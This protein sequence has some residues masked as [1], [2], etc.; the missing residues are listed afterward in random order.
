MAPKH[1]F[2]QMLLLI[3][4]Y[5]QLPPCS[6]QIPTI[7]NR[8]TTTPTPAM[9]TPQVPTTPNVPQM[10]TSPAT[11]PMPVTS[12]QSSPNPAT[13]PSATTLASPDPSTQARTEPP[14]Q[15]A[16]T[17]APTAQPPTTQTMP[18][19][20][21]PTI[22]PTEPPPPP[23]PS[24][25]TCSMAARTVTCEQKG[26]TGIPPDLPEYTQTLYLSKNTFNILPRGAFGHLP[27]LIN[28]HLV[29]CG[30]LSIAD[31]AFNGLHHLRVLNLRNNQLT[32]VDLVLGGMPELET[33]DLEHNRLSALSE[34]V[35][36]N[37]PNLR[38]L[39]IGS[40]MGL[41]DIS[42]GA[43]DSNPMLRSLSISY[44]A[45]SRLDPMMFRNLTLLETL[46][47]SGNPISQIPSGAFQHLSSLQELLLSNM[48]L[49]SLSDTAFQGLLQLRILNL[50]N[51]R[52]TNL[53]IPTL[54]PLTLL[55]TLVLAQNPWNCGCSM[56]NFINWLKNTSLHQ[57]D[58][59]TT[60]WKCYTPE[61]LQE[62]LAYTI[63]QEDF[64]CIPI[65]TLTP[66][67]RVISYHDFTVF[68]CTARGD[69]TPEIEWYQPD[70]SKVS[71]TSN[72]E[73]VYT[74]DDGTVL[75]IQ[76]PEAVN[77]GRYNCTARNSNGASS[78][79]FSLTV[80]GIPTT[81]G[82]TTTGEPTSVTTGLPPCTFASIQ[83]KVGEITDTT[84]KM[85]WTGYN[86]PYL[87][88]YIIQTTEFGSSQ[89]TIK[90][91]GEADMS[92]VV[93][94]LTAGT[95][96]VV[97][98]TV[99]LEMCPSYTTYDQCEQVTT[100]GKTDDGIAALVTKHRNEIIGT[101]LATFFG[102]LFIL[103]SIFVILWQYRKPKSFTG[104]DFK[105][106]QDTVQ[107]ADL[108][109][110]ESSTGQISNQHIRYTGSL[111][112]DNRGA[113]LPDEDEQLNRKQ[114]V[115]T[116]SHEAEVYS[117]PPDALYS[118]PETKGKS[119]GKGKG[120]GKRGS[121]APL[122][123][124]PLDQWDENKRSSDYMVPTTPTNDADAPV[125]E[126]KLVDQ[127]INDG[128]DVGEF[129]HLYE[130]L[131]SPKCDCDPVI[132][133]IIE[134]NGHMPNHDH[135]VTNGP[136]SGKVRF[137]LP[138]DEGKTPVANGSL[139]KQDILKV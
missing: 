60:Q 34:N 79:T 17:M 21:P 120:K 69:P 10:E 68:Q 2:L 78:K 48:E 36:N 123:E 112:Y 91:A 30:I 118:I 41:R 57:I 121:Q 137:S 106:T 70:N 93:T 128:P 37:L 109:I 89:S 82:P 58:Y 94:D 43:F 9:T 7:S 15:P 131:D 90:L 61:S 66:D 24:R 56:G 31:G 75:I 46:T 20:V 97:C 42:I 98:V 133:G 119:K 5:I 40:N 86:D 44:C 39:H 72:A 103:A 59:Y 108:E 100:G 49:S 96:Y 55:T 113:V 77:S 105:T 29:S 4:V 88:G 1:A 45:L 130:E 132:N 117:I 51:N 111:T 54:T 3:G 129:G 99:F 11:Q 104:Y 110:G 19:T 125:L 136:N 64:A 83:V 73:N 12:M 74:S 76:R 85:E 80:T 107:F 63:P 139:T 87:K 13:A 95:N 71:T 28:L 32:S 22:P 135:S 35:L 26:L 23:C 6:A 53:D 81:P 16:P 62:R 47:L 134:S 138:E 8:R 122:I 126:A 84:I 14:T 127:D 67:S 115:P 50:A 116:K 101:A 38:T 92:F 18:P 114:Q 25:C 33:L 65:F 124:I 102:T 52:L 27:N